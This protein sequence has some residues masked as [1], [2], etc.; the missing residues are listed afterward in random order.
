MGIGALVAK[1]QIPEPEYIKIKGKIFS[2]Q[3][4]FGFDAS[5][6]VSIGTTQYGFCDIVF[7]T[8]QP[9]MVRKLDNVIDIGDILEARCYYFPRKDGTFGKLTVA[10][11]GFTV[12]K[13]SGIKKEYTYYVNDLAEVKVK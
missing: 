13:P 3:A 10:N 2:E 11:G 1:C 5:Y 8:G 9:H 12:I 7:D 4:S 6:K